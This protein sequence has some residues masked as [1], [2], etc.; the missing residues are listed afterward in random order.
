MITDQSE[1]SLGVKGVLGDKFISITTKGEASRYTITAGKFYCHIKNP[2][3]LMGFLGSESVKEQ[4]S[5]VITE[6]ST[7]LSSLNSE[8]PLGHTSQAFK[9]IC[10]FF[11]KR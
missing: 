5:N 3:G 9:Q 10:W 4:L 2:K 8:K 11:F 6:V 1:A 7:F